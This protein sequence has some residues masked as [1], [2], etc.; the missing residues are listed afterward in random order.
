MIKKI[1]KYSDARKNFLEIG[2]LTNTNEVVYHKPQRLNTPHITQYSPSFY[3]L[4]KNGE[5]DV[6]YPNKVR[7][8]ITTNV[9]GLSC[10]IAYIDSDDSIIFYDQYLSN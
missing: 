8:E 9:E 4:D 10:A 5:Y 3:T 1:F 2:M 7:K 6:V